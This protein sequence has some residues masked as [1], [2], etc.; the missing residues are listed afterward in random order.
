MPSGITCPS[1]TGAICDSSVSGTIDRRRDEL[2][3]WTSL[4]ATPAGPV[5]AAVDRGMGV[6]QA[7]RVFQVSVSWIYKALA[8]RRHSGE[9]TARPQINHV[10]PN[11]SAQHAT[12]RTKLSAEPALTPAE[13]RA[14][15]Q[16]EPQVSISLGGTWKTLHTLGPTRKETRHAAEQS[17]PDVAAAREAW[18][19]TQPQPNPTQ[20]VFIDETAGSSPGAGSG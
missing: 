15:L 18:R 8:R 3:S 19:D 11:L 2:A 10:P 7:A 1:G 5:L 12:I 14:W 13:L 4:C 17:R 6:C 20:L 9:T 16:G